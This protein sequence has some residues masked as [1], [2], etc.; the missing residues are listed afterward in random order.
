MRRGQYGKG[1]WAVCGPGW[2]KGPKKI[3]KPSPDFC[4]GLQ[5]DPIN[6]FQVLSG[7]KLVPIKIGP[8]KTPNLA[9]NSLFRSENF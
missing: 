9:Q 8:S 6:M 2:Q 1:H 7:K 5:F 3:N 4:T